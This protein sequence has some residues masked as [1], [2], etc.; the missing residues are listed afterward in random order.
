MSAV[1]RTDVV[2]LDVVAI[3]VV[4]F[5]VVGLD[6][7]PAVLVLT[8]VVVPAVDVL[9][10]VP[11][12]VVGAEL[13]AD[14]V[15]ELEGGP[16]TAVD[17]ELETAVEV[18]IPP[19]PLVVVPESPPCD[20]AR[21]AAAP[22]PTPTRIPIVFPL[23]PEEVSL[24]PIVAS[25]NFEIPSAWNPGGSGVAPGRVA[26]TAIFGFWPV[27]K[28]AK[29]FRRLHSVPVETGTVLS[30]VRNALK[31]MVTSST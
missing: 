11:T 9:E 22:P 12:L 23:T 25:R 30:S 19:I 2:G 31:L 10:L 5:E 28:S 20:R 8:L 17:V 4:G 7:L 24:E 15:V 26:P 16:E 18:L 13:E 21:A 1:A 14:V 6:V 29:G 27:K 3:D